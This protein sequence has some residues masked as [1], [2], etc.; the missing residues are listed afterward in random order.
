MDAP[1]TFPA[2]AGYFDP[3]GR[4]N[5]DE[6]VNRL[7]A[8]MGALSS[9]YADPWFVFAATPASAMHR[10]DG[11]CLAVHGRVENRQ[12]LQ[13]ELGL[14]GDPSFEAILRSAHAA[15]PESAAE[16]FRGSF[17]AAAWDR[18]R[19]SGWLTVDQLGHRALFYA[20][21]P[22]GSLVFAS[23][24]VTLLAVLP[25][26]PEPSA[27]AVASWLLELYPPHG[28]T[29]YRGVRRLGAARTLQL[30]ESGW[31]ERLYWSA[32]HERPL[33][34]SRT[35]LT[36]ALWE[37]VV[38]S[39]GAKVDADDRPAVI[40]SGGIDSSVAAAAAAEAAAEPNQLPRAYS[41]VFPDRPDIDESERID[42]IVDAL[43]L[44]AVEL[45]LQ[46]SGGLALALEYADAWSLPLSGPGS[47]LEQPLVERAGAE[48]CTVILDGQA[49][50][51][52]FAS[53]PYLMAD[54]LLR[55]RLLSSL[56]LADAFLPDSF[57]GVRRR[58]YTYRAWKL[59]GVQPAVPHTLHK[60]LWRLRGRERMLPD[61]FAA[62]AETY[63]PRAPFTWDWKANPGPRSWAHQVFMTTQLRDIIGVSDYLRHRAWT[64]G[65]EARPPLLDVDLIEFVLRLPPDLGV[66]VDLP[67]RP[68]IREAMRGR[69][70]EIVRLNPVK[71][72]V[73]AFYYENLA[74]PDLA[75]IARLL[76]EGSPE[77]AAYADLRLVRDLLDRQPGVGAPGWYD[78][79]ASAWKLATTEIWLRRERD[80]SFV[81]RALSD[82]AVVPTV[83]SDH[84]VRRRVTDSSF[85]PT[86]TA[87]GSL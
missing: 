55:G 64:V 77:V 29:M 5:G 7:E 85:L 33:E 14:T 24:V 83:R 82:P 59:L 4:L 86:S 30:D 71:S 63:D 69:V 3:R 53:S 31:R 28:E 84:R 51:E 74:G 40:L 10:A 9:R 6:T 49:G 18:G 43:D 32:R 70:P 42:A 72:N 35:E 23:E 56:R 68:L 57:T 22:D 19:K 11:R 20:P 25:T 12:A 46:P 78:W 80:S 81:A 2:A 48:G 79:F 50:D 26:R 62:P 47:A 37:Q 54:R 15:W 1:G 13:H 38:R 17:I 21:R 67:D 44:D 66:G 41:A 34:G 65:A 60:A 52:V 45:Q 87:A 75:P 36:E 76:M 61:W 73:A 27:E 58:R 16:R 8:V 39:V